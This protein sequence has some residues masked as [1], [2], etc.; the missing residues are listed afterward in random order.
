MNCKKDDLITKFNAFITNSTYRESAFKMLSEEL[1][2]IRKAIPQCS[3]L[4]TIVCLTTNLNN[5]KERLYQYRSVPK[6]LLSE[7][8]NTIF[9]SE[10]KEEHLLKN[11]I[12]FKNQHEKAPKNAA[13]AVSYVDTTAVEMQRALMERDTISNELA[14]ERQQTASLRKMLT[15]ANNRHAVMTQNLNDLRTQIQKLTAASEHDKNIIQTLKKAN[16]QILDK[17]TDFEK[18]TSDLQA[19]LAQRFIFP[20]FY[21]ESPFKDPQSALNNLCAFLS[22]QLHFVMDTN[23][24]LDNPHLIKTLIEHKHFVYFPKVVIDELDKLKQD[25]AK[26][27]QV[28]EAI[29]TIKELQYEKNPNLVFKTAN[30]DLLQT[31]QKDK[32]DNR[33]VALGI[34]IH[35]LYPKTAF[36]LSSD[37]NLHVRAMAEAND[38]Q[39]LALKHIEYILKHL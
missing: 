3:S 11:S 7:L 1:S 33:I 39:V 27:T 15:D 5:L 14:T 23:I 32:P 31:A 38:I 10:I 9:M 6:D 13:P 19:K 12:V 28:S 2:K 34:E 26:R 18:K 37:N 35:R 4:D 8:D 17:L 21:Q 36:L 24:I 20:A 30:T 25:K 16:V 22:E 29:D